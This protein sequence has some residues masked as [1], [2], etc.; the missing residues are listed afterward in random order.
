MQ[1]LPSIQEAVVLH[2]K[3]LRSFMKPSNWD[4]S[5]PYPKRV[6]VC[7]YKRETE[8]AQNA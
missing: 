6:K 7:V 1:S 5:S 2:E 3:Q 4:K 8:Q